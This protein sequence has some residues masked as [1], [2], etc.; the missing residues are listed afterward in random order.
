MFIPLNSTDSGQTVTYAVTTSD[1]SKL[2]PTITPSSN[3][4]LQFN[5]VVNGVTETMRLPV[6]RQSGAQHHGPDRAVGELGILQWPANLSQRDRWAEWHR[7]SLRHPRRQRTTFGSHQIAGA[8]VDGRGV[9][10]RSSIHRGRHAGH[11]PQR[12]AGSSS[13]EFFITEEAARFL[14]F[15]YTAFGVQTT[16]QS[17][18]KNLRSC[19]EE[20]LTQDTNGIGY[21]SESRNDQFGVD[22]YRHAERRAGTAGANGS[23]GHDHRDRDRQRRHKYADDTVVHRQHC[24]EHAPRARHTPPI[25]LPRSFPPPRPV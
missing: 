14:D 20:S 16:G 12:R 5:V 1:A 25:P 13:T 10:S 7:Q 11:G 22:H 21:L 17:D 23:H 24:P 6:A 15:N 19:P 3:K 9:Q 2:T 4:T 18:D 8:V